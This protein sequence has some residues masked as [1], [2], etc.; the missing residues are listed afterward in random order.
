[1]QKPNPDPVAG[2]GFIARFLQAQAPEWIFTVA[3]VF[4]VVVGIIDYLT[5]YDIDFYPFYSLPILL[6]AYFGHRSA[7]V[8]IVLLSTLAWWWA[9]AAAGHVYTHEWLRGWELLARMI[10]FCLALLAGLEH[11]AIP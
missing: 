2:S 9:D 11:P 10:F 5:G 8:I 3:F 1:M 7:A 6:A 4:V